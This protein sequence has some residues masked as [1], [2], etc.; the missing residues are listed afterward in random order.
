MVKRDL[1]PFLG[2]RNRTLHL[3][4]VPAG[5]RT[6]VLANAETYPNTIDRPTIPRTLW[7]R[8]PA[9][10]GGLRDWGPGHLAK[11]NFCRRDRV[12]VTA[13]WRKDTGEHT[14]SL[15]RTRHSIWD[16]VDVKN[17]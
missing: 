4:A 2:G 11:E 14:L 9:P 3:L 15:R 7:Q 10:F 8:T 13:R 5:N 12:R 1:R 17:N 16:A 6:P